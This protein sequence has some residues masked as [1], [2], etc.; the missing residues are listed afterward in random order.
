M[1]HCS[2]PGDNE[3]ELLSF[4]PCDSM[5]ADMYLGTRSMQLYFPYIINHNYYSATGDHFH[6]NCGKLCFPLLETPQL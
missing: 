5:T 3:G 2:A 1:R 6:I 4:E